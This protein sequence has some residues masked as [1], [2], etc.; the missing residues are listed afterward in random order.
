MAKVWA[1]IAEINCGRVDILVQAAGIVG[2][3]NLKTEDMDPGNFDAV[4]RV[5]VRGIFPGIAFHDRAGTD[6]LSTLHPLPVRKETPECWLIENADAKATMRL[7]S[8]IPP[9][10]VMS[11]WSTS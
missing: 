10:H 1:Q 2:A 6:G 4:F 7:A 11:R 9:Y 5:N 8:V 3:T